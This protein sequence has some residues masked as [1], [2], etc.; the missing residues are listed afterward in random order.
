MLS[1]RLAVV[2]AVISVSIT[3]D[4]HSHHSA[5]PK[6]LPRIRVLPSL[7]GNSC[8]VKNSTLSDLDSNPNLTPGFD[9][10][11]VLLFWL[12]ILLPAPLSIPIPLTVLESNLKLHKTPIY[13][14]A[15]LERAVIQQRPDWL[16]ARYGPSRNRG[17]RVT[18]RDRRH[19][20]F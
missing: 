5:R 17:G 7:P 19:G 6:Q 10:G 13:D 18:D 20:S 15:Q 9:L 1:V 12:S 14:A 8:S 16:S 2:S 11:P 3:V 4:L